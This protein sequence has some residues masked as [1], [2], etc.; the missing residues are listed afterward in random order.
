M[1]QNA[2]QLLD[3]LHVNYQGLADRMKTE[4][5]SIKLKSIESEM[6]KINILTRALTSYINYYKIK[7]NKK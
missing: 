2:V 7:N 5:E 1:N 3:E 4:N 6:N